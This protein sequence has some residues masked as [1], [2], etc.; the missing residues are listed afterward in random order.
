MSNYLPV[1]VLKSQCMTLKQ[2]Y[3]TVQDGTKFCCWLYSFKD[4]ILTQNWVI[5]KFRHVWFTI[6]SCHDI[7]VRQPISQVHS[8]QAYLNQCKCSKPDHML[9]KQTVNIYLFDLSLFMSV[10]VTSVRGICSLNC[11]LIWL[12]HAKKTFICNIVV[13]IPCN[14]ISK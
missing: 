12:L 6:F 13:L 5:C 11:Y 4:L 2:I 8:I 7:L 3:S 9:K 1:S 10:C 14:K